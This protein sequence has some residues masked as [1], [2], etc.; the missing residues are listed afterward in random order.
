MKRTENEITDAAEID[1]LI[2]QGRLATLSL[3]RS[4]EP[5]IVTMNYGFDGERMAL[6]F[7]CAHEGLK[8]DF[9][10]ENPRTCATI[11]HDMGYKTGKCDHAYRS[12]V[13]R[14][15][16]HVVR[17][18]GEK[19][20]GLDILIRHQEDDW[21]TVRSRTLPDEQAYDRVCVLRLDIDHITGKEG[22]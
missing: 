10:G 20:H 15:R 14:G 4:G 17:D 9:I 5:Y 21:E 7:H 6:Y 19:K 18:R 16:M 11:V 3:C 2:L 1:G 22:L 8:I 13:I 12:V